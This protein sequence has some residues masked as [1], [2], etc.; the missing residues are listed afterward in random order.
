M[1]EDYIDFTIVHR[2]WD[3]Q[4]DFVYPS[5][6]N[7]ASCVIESIQVCRAMLRDIKIRSAFVS[8]AREFDRSTPEPWY[9][10][11]Y[12]NTAEAVNYYI[13]TVLAVF[14]IVYIDDSITTPSCLGGHPR[15]A[16]RFYFDPCN[17]S[18]LLN[19]N[20]SQQ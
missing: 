9:H 20:V 11:Q 8:L 3:G 17:Q 12:R 13:D 4:P 7:L 14:P 10:N 1:T 19:G 5:D 16:W 15:R 6:G 2:R 18:I